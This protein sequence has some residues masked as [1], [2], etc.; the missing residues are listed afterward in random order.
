MASPFPSESFKILIVCSGN[1]CR[2]P[3][4]YALLRKAVPDWVELSSAGTLDIEKAGPPPL[5]LEVAESRG[6]DL[7]AFRS[8]PLRD[9]RPDGADLVIGMTLEHVA[10][11]VV[12]GGAPAEKSFQLTELVQLLESNGKSPATSPEM[13]REL[14]A[15]AHGL[16]SQQSMFRPAEA[17]EDPIGGPRRAFVAMADRLDDLCHRLTSLLLSSQ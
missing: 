2:S 16:R 9:S 17:V 3:Y 15:A 13:A 4:A 12:D 5:L 8:T 1:R 10:Q 14:V 11:S 7:S 6:H